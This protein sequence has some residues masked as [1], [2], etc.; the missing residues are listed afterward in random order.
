MKLMLKNLL[1]FA[2]LIFSSSAFAQQMQA[3]EMADALRE[4]GKIYI[5]L[6]VIALIFISLVVFLIY[7]DRK[8]S[9]IENKLKQEGVF[10]QKNETPRH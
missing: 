4:N 10:S 3:P 6:G 7:L 9:R 5:V 1:A 8:V 2:L